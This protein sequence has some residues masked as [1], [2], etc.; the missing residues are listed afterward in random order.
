V[1]PA[2]RSP[3]PRGGRCAERPGLAHGC[4]PMG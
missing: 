3:P 1:S 2:P 4:V